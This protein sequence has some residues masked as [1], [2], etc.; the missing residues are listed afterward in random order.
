MLVAMVAKQKG[1]DVIIS[2]VNKTRIAMAEEIGFTVVN[3]LETDLVAFVKERTEG[4]LADVVFEVSGAQ[5]AVDIMT[6]V[7]GMVAIHGQPKEVNLFKFFW[8]ELNLIGARVYEKE[9]YNESIQLIT[10]ELLP[11][12]KIIT[13]V[14]P[15]G[16]I[17]NVFEDIDNNP[18][19]MKYLVDC[20][21]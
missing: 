17:L 19:G 16:K 15:L 21:M 12:E 11:I 4:R 18:E 14:E 10:E 8:K 2:E 5:S 3:P 7:A 1:A 6:E 20:T 9:D 13:A